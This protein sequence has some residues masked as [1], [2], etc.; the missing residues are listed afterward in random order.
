VKE[1]RSG[2]DNRYNRDE[3]TSEW[4]GE[5][6]RDWRVPRR[7]WQTIIKLLHR[8]SSSPLP[9]Y[10]SASA[11][12]D[13]HASFFTDKISKLRLSL[14][15]SSSSTSSSPHSPSSLKTP[16]DFSTFKPASESEISKILFN[17]HVKF[18]VSAFSIYQKRYE[19]HSYNEILI[20]KLWTS[21]SSRM[22]VINH[23]WSATK[24][25]P[26]PQSV[27]ETSRHSVLSGDR[28]RDLHMPY[29]RVSFRL[30]YHWPQ[31]LTH[32]SILLVWHSW[33]CTKLVQILSFISLFSCQMQ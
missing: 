27:A 26:H 5:S 13:S 8:N 12:A 17:A 3:L 22:R 29:S 20:K 30:R 1:W 6:R 28:D 14:T 24:Q 18:L 7:L 15:R 16:P 2:D 31:Y 11:L 33:H 10:T 23:N 4:G 9:A 32:S 25:R 19:I 21:S